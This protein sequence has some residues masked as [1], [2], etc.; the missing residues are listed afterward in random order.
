MS[1]FI[2][3]DLGPCVADD[4]GHHFPWLMDVR[5]F[6]TYRNSR[7]T[8]ADARS[9]AALG[10]SLGSV[11]RKRIPETEHLFGGAS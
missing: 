8:E 5:T 9:M 4:R 6:G 1:D 10:V 2:G 3:N 11:V 7:R